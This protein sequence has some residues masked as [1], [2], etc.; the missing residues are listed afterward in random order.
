MDVDSD[1]EVYIFATLD[2]EL[3]T[4]IIRKKNSS[5]ARKKP[6]KKSVSRLAHRNANSPSSA[7]RRENTP[8]KANSGKEIQ[9]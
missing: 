7:K 6:A 9:S 1:V 2:H 8:L 3:R 4:G 5:A